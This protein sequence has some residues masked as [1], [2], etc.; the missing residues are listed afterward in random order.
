MLFDEV[1]KKLPLEVNPKNVYLSM[2]DTNIDSIKKRLFKLDELSDEELYHLVSNTYS[3]IL[4]EIFIS[5]NMDLIKFLYTNPRFL[6]TFNNV[7]S[8]PDVKLSYLQMVYCNKL[9]YDYFTAKGD[10]DDYI[11]ALLINL[12]K[13]VNRSVTPG[14]VGLGLGEELASYLTNARFSSLKEQIQVKRLNLVIINQ[15][16]DIMNLQMIINIYGKLFDR[17]TP[18]FDGIMYDY[19]TVDQFASKEMEDVY[20]TI[21]VAILEIVNNLPEDIMYHLLKNFYESHQLINLNKKVR[22]NIYSFCKD[23]YPRLDYTLQVLNSEGIVLP[24]S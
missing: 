22:F 2:D 17:I 21:N 1:V 11:K 9:A 13:T 3:Y 24:M 6:M 10:K 18:L 5:K 7:M 4:D 15:S 8:R 19:L 16:T 23:D 20:A 14:L 12:I